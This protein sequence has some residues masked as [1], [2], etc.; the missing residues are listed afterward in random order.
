MPLSTLKSSAKN[1]RKLGIIELSKLEG[2]K[3]TSTGKI[4]FKILTIDK[5]DM[6]E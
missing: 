4:I 1:L 5:G 2:V 3:L 6:N